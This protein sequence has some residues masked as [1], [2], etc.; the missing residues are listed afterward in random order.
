MKGNA[1]RRAGGRGGEHGSSPVLR[2]HAHAGSFAAE[3]GHLHHTVAPATKRV[4]HR[5]EGVGR[6]VARGVGRATT[7]HVVGEEA[8]DGAPFGIGGALEHQHHHRILDRLASAEAMAGLKRAR[9]SGKID[10]GD[11]GHVDLVAGERVP[12]G[13]ERAQAGQLLLGEREARPG[14][15]DLHAETVRHDVRHRADHVFGA[16]RRSHLVERLR[17]GLAGVEPAPARA[18]AGDAA[19][20]G[21][22]DEDAEALARGVRPACD[23]A[24]RPAWSTSACW[25]RAD[26]RSAG[27][28]RSPA[29]GRTTSPSPR[30]SVSA[31]TASGARGSAL[32]APGVAPGSQDSTRRWALLP[33]NPKALT[34]AR[35]VPDGEA[36]QGAASESRENRPIS[37]SGESA[38]G[39]GGSTPASIATSTLRRP[40]APATVIRWPRLPLSEP[41][42]PP[43]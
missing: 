11:H 16:Q 22:A 29:I 36:C 7:L 33:P 43:G 21:H 2:P 40:A 35:R 1:Q 15:V 18:P 41:T 20:A 13:I 30:R 19:I 39:A 28:N 4:G 14:G 9:I 23:Q 42:G 24:S 17:G 25:A 6:A 8:Q 5:H 31:R 38:S 10:R 34:A 26:W 32:R 12:G 3:R 37:G 27:G